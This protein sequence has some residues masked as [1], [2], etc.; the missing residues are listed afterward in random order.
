MLLSGRSR[1]VFIRCGLASAAGLVLCMVAT[2]VILAL[3][4]PRFDM[5][6]PWM[7]K[8]LNV[9]QALLLFFSLFAIVL[10]F[11]VGISDSSE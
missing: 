3:R 1:K 10:K 4:S 8:A 11:L 9:L 6:Q 2:I 7:D 5:G